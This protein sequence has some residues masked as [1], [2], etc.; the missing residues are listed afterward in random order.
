MRS[1]SRRQVP[2]ETVLR[3]LRIEMQRRR[4]LER[5]YRERRDLDIR[6]Q[7]PDDEQAPAGAKPEAKESTP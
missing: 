5:I 6:V 1:S 7:K 4:E 3:E 2:E